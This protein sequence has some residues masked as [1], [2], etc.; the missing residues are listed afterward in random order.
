MAT[1]G[2]DC[3]NWQRRRRFGYRR[4]HIL[5]KPTQN[6]FVVNLDGCMHR[7][8]LNETLFLPGR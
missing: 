2:R 8:L 7:E 6:G 1:G 3:A 4:L 5:R